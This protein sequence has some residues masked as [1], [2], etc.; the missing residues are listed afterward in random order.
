[1]YVP[2]KLR[3]LEVCL[4]AVYEMLDGFFFHE[5]YDRLLK[6]DGDSIPANLHDRIRA[7]LEE[8]EYEP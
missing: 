2:E 6:N 1:M 5:I 3:T 7:I 4:A 8:S